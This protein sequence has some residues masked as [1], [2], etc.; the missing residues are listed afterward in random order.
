M[1]CTSNDMLYVSEGGPLSEREIKL[2][3]PKSSYEIITNI[4]K[5]YN[6]VLNVDIKP[7]KENF[8]KKELIPNWMELHFYSIPKKNGKR[9]TLLH[10]KNS[11]LASNEPQLL[12]STSIF[13]CHE[14]ETDLLYITHFL[15]DLSIQMKCDII[16]FDYQGFGYNYKNSNNKPKLDT[17]FDDGQEALKIA[18]DDLKYKIENI[19]IMGKGIGAMTGLYLSSKEEYSKCKSLILC[20]PII[21]MNKIDIKIMRNIN[22]KCL[23]IM[24][25]DKNKEIENN[26]IIYLWGEI[27]Q[28]QQWFPKKKK[29]VDKFDEFKKYMNQSFFDDL[30]F[31]HRSKFIIKLRDYIYPENEFIKNRKIGDSSVGESTESDTNLNLSSNKIVNIDEINEIRNEIRNEDDN[32]EKEEEKEKENIFN[33]HE[34]QINND[35]DY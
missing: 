29:K 17:I 11:C 31:K 20:N 30:Y 5:N 24:E 7:T 23:L 14:N 13:Y 18:L 6:F 27:P 1:M 33:E 12:D 22:C 16:S 8:F 21:N 26:D 34:I 19:I 2:K 25:I 35:D 3:A 32:K 9:I 15:I 28:G 10:I 4:E